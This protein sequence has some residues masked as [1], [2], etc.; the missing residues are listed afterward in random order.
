[1]KTFEE[2]N[3]PRFDNEVQAFN[4]LREKEG[5]VKYL[6]NFW[7]D[8]MDGQEQTSK[9]TYHIL[10]E[11]GSCDLTDYF[12]QYFPPLFPADGYEFWNDLCKVV[13]TVKGIHTIRNFDQTYLG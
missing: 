11:F 8:E 3:K 7:R 5:M 12:V 4:A 13:E 10:L 9:R 2:R 6:G 1:M